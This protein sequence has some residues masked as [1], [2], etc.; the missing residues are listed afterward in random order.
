[1]SKKRDSALLLEDILICSS[2][3]VEYTK[4]LDYDTF[5]NSQITV[6]AV[7]RNFEIIGEASSK[8]DSDFKNRK[9]RDSLE[10]FKKLQKIESFTIMQGLIIWWYGTL[11]QIISKSFSFK[12]KNVLNK[13]Q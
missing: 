7:E 8:F 9:S 6:D 2:R 5:I 11:L 10:R 4:D 12:C 3:I 1:M 13:I